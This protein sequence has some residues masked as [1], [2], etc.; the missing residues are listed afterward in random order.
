MK[1]VKFRVQN[2]KKVQDTGLI[3]VS[4]ITT[5]V[6]KNE[7]G[8]SAILR[9]LSKLNPT[10]G[11]AYDGLKEFPRR[12][13]TDEFE[14]QDWP[15][16]TGI[17]TLTDDER[18][19]LA[20]V[21]AE[22][23]GAE[24][25]A[26]T[27]RYSGELSV[28]YEPAQQVEVVTSLTM[29]EALGPMIDRLQAKGAPEGKGDAWGVLR[30]KI[31]QAL[32][33]QLAN[34]SGRP[35]VDVAPLAEVKKAVQVITDGLT[36]DWHEQLLGQHL[37]KLKALER[38]AGAQARLE[39]A[40]KW[41]AENLPKFIYF[42]RYDVLDSAVYLPTFKAQSKAKDR[43][44]RT[45]SCLFKHVN[46]DP[47]AVL[48]LGSHQR[49]Q[50][51]NKDIRRQID[52]RTVRVT[53]AA[54]AMTEKFSSWWKQ[55]RHHFQY[56]VD[57]DYFRVWVS[58]DL[59][60]SWIEL[61][62]RSTGMQYFF[63]FYLVF[64]VESAETHKGCILLLDEPGNSL[65]GTAQK[66]IVAFLESI[67]KTNQTI[68]S[69]HQPFMVDADHL[70]RARA[71]FEDPT[72]GYTKVS[73]DVWPKDKDCLF[74]LQAALGYQLVQSLFVG[75]SQI[76]VEGITDYWLLK[77]LD[78]ALRQTGRTG[79]RQD[80]TLVPAGGASKAAPLASMLLGHDIEVFVLLDG[81]AAG[82]SEGKKLK[83]SLFEDM[84]NKVRFVAE[85]LPAGATDTECLLPEDWV[86]AAA[87]EGYPGVDF[88]FDATE[89]SKP[90]VLD[91][92]KALLIRKAVRV[93]K[94]RVAGPLRDRI[95]AKPTE[96]P[97][98][99]LD[100]AQALMDAVNAAMSATG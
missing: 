1:L 89:K 35:M 56:D 83:N 29:V 30:L 90:N 32:Q 60:P 52:E 34:H 47:D 88:T 64:L 17:F 69:T 67:S 14:L 73:A 38:R 65:H 59:D 22:V 8:K 61:D 80:I 50:G 5:L 97:V 26:C 43:R 82:S 13:F 3:E 48:S 42:D 78:A 53:A 95:Y 94:W 51:E 70:E 27:R 28:G 23:A 71:V 10:D 11:E 4:D 81:D 21:C 24:S 86:L 84:P 77:A 20:K 2:Y 68:Y 55:R 15:V 96:I 85:F 57:G 37:T 40:D 25:V 45:T 66:E 16:A 76:I 74:P 54:Q 58:D 19:A 93:E 44:A 75:K 49:G 6:G 31:V 99:N 12:R 36:E 18:L 63:S 62:Q 7:S 91:R 79:L 41:V 100:R 72:T 87:R 33:Q 92:L 98:A 9:G 46:L 39:A